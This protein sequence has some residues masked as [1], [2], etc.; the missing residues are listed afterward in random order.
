M[1][2]A[3]FFSHTGSDGSSPS[4]RV[5]RTGYVASSV[6]EVLA[7]ASPDVEAVMA[8]W[9]SRAQRDELFN[10]SYSDVGVSCLYAPVST[11]GYYWT[12]VF[13]RP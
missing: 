8:A 2:T 7:A 11:Y 6:G 10:P 12:V 13:A 1:V 9:L 5:A 4:D 3:N